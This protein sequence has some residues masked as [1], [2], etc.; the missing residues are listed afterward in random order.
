MITHTCKSSTCKS[1]GQVKRRGYSK[2]KCD[3]CKRN[4]GQDSDKE[5]QYLET[6]VFHNNNE[7]T[8]HLHFCS[9]KCCLKFIPKIKSDYFVS[10][11]YLHYDENKKGLGVKDFLEA[12]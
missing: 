1:C 12:I 9:W 8:D 6:K 3:Q 4:L 11:P 2:M 5:R 7:E 10:L